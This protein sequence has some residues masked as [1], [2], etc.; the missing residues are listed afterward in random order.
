VGHNDSGLQ[1][2]DAKKTLQTKI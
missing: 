1:I 2:E